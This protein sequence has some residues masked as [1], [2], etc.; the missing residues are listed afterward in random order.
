MDKKWLKWKSGPVFIAGV[1]MILSLCACSKLK[2]LVADSNLNGVGQQESVVSQ[3]ELASFVSSVRPQQ[4][5]AESILKRARYFQKVRKY[6]LAIQ[7]CRSEHG[8]E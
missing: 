2:S 3:K 4:E 5:N 6:R 1:L 7:E 8:S